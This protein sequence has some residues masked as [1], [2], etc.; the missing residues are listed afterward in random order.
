MAPSASTITKSSTSSVINWQPEG[1]TG[2]NRGSSRPPAPLAVWEQVKVIWLQSSSIY[3]VKQPVLLPKLVRDSLIF[4]T[5]STPSSCFTFSALGSWESCWGKGKR[6]LFTINTRHSNTKTTAVPFETGQGK[7]RFQSRNILKKR[8]NEIIR[9]TI[10]V[11]L[12]SQR[13]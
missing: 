9:R 5:L 2:H 13:K 12:A 8:K 6:V 1:S 10:P 4:V 7:A 11:C 3:L